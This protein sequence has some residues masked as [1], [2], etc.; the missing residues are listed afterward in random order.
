MGEL[1]SVRLRFDK[2]RIEEMGTDKWTTENER[3]WIID[4]RKNWGNGNKPLFLGGGGMD[5]FNSDAKHCRHTLCRNT[6]SHSRV[7][8]FHHKKMWLTQELEIPD[9]HSQW[10]VL[11]GSSNLS[12]PL[13]GSSYHPSVKTICRSTLVL[14]WDN[15]QRQWCREGWVTLA[16]SWG[17]AHYIIKHKCHY[18]NVIMQMYYFN[19]LAN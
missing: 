4:K 17:S 15:L 13:W 7:S 9:L 8:A 12:S 19:K 10:R 11:I 5:S 18:A 16:W 2:E 3:F 14:C 1:R 6:K